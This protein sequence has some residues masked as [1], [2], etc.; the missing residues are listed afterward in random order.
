MI[1]NAKKTIK[2]N[3][4]FLFCFKKNCIFA[5]INYCLTSK[6]SRKM[7]KFM[8]LC[9][10]MLMFC[11]VSAQT[12]PT[13]TKI[14]SKKNGSYTDLKEN[15]YE[16]KSNLSVANIYFSLEVTNGSTALSAGDELTIKFEPFNN[17]DELKFTLTADLE[18]GATIIFDDNSTYPAMDNINALTE[19]VSNQHYKA[20]VAATVVSTKNLG[21]LGKGKNRDLTFTFDIV[22]VTSIENSILEQIKIY[23]TNVRDM[24]HI[25]NLENANVSIFAINGQQVK[26]ANNVNGDITIDM[27]NFANGIYVLAIKMNDAVCTKKI[28]VNHEK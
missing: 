17:N 18:A 19:I 16:Y 21:D 20:S 27:S 5:K 11:I 24:F 9:A 12:Q 15:P 7:K 3:T 6:N 28:H 10:G 8:F 14:F 22:N 26:E 23:P 1:I 4:L 25:E 2:K 13:V